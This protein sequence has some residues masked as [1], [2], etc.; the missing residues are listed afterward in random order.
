MTVYACELPPS[1]IKV[2]TK[3]TIALW[4]QDDLLGFSVE[5][6]LN[7]RKEYWDVIRIPDY[8]GVDVLLQQVEKIKPDVIVLYQPKYIH[9]STLPL[10]LMQN[11][12]WIK[13]VI[14]NLENNSVE[15][16][17]KQQVVIQEDSDLLSIVEGCPRL[18]CPIVPD[19]AIVP[20]LAGP[21]PQENY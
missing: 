19:L 2:V 8:E 7:T 1:Q 13:V 15:V 4:G 21:G 14:V 11:Q 17:S 12:Q 5:T 9:Y 20:V 10:Q 16:I 3:K 18:P 6:L